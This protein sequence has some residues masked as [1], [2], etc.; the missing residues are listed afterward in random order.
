M[1]STDTGTGCETIAHP[2]KVEL[3]HEQREGDGEGKIVG[4]TEEGEIKQF[5]NVKCVL[6]V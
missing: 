4:M 2:W 5:K 6:C 3:G 1:F